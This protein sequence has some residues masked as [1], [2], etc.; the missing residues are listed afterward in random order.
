MTAPDDRPSDTVQQ[1][2]RYAEGDLT[3]TAGEA[4]EAMEAAQRIRA[5]VHRALDR[6]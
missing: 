4:R 1:W 6:A 5:Q 2:L 3:T